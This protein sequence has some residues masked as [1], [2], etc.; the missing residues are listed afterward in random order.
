MSFSLEL[1]WW[2]ERTKLF[3][4]SDFGFSLI[5]LSKRKNRLLALNLISKAGSHTVN[6]LLTSWIF[7]DK[8]RSSFRVW[9]LWSP[10]NFCEV[11]SLYLLT[12]SRRLVSTLIQFLHKNENTRVDTDRVVPV[13]LEI[14]RV[15][16]TDTLG[17]LPMLPYLILLINFV[18]HTW[19]CLETIYESQWF[20]LTGGYRWTLAGVRNLLGLFNNANCCPVGKRN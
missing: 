17:A 9:S 1:V 18:D 20:I 12:G 10:K 8:S 11:D 5:T 13:D 6:H 19:P 16:F 4:G 14:Y 2:M 3:F 7:L 15:D